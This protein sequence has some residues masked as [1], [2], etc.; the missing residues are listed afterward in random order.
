MAA[1]Q[2]AAILKSCF[3]TSL[4]LDIW[5]T[6]NRSRGSVNSPEICRHLLS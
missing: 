1:D 4:V 2:L 5:P 6:A 3:A